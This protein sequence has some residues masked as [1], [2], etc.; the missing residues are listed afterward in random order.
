MEAQRIKE[1]IAKLREELKKPFHSTTTKHS[2]YHD[3]KRLEKLLDKLEQKIVGIELS[4]T[5]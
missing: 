2:I 5:R 1:K 4:R 3:V